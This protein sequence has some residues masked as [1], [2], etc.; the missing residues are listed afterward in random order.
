MGLSAEAVAEGLRTGFFFN[1][2]PHIIVTTAQAEDTVKFILEMRTRRGF[3]NEA[4]G[5][6][7][8]GLRHVISKCKRWTENLETYDREHSRS[9]PIPT[10]SDLFSPGLILMKYGN[11]SKPL[12]LILFTFSKLWH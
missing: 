5:V 10:S 1:A 11:A 2:F 12:F 6:R 8:R 4:Q 9:L 3:L 7:R